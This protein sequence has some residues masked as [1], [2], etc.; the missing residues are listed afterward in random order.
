MIYS[1]VQARAFPIHTY[2]IAIRIRLKNVDSDPML[3][4]GLLTILLSRT[5]V[6]KTAIV[7]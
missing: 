6:T 7:Y 3:F 5:A 2:F 4:R 1:T